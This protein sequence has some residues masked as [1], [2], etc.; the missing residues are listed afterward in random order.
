MNFFDTI[1]EMGYKLTP[2][3]DDEIIEISKEY[4][5]CE[6]HIT[7]YLKEKKIIGF[8]EVKEKLFDINDMAHIYQSFRELQGDIKDFA[9]KSKYEVVE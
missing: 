9:S 3:H 4:G 1:T 6:T 8:M 2:L 5:L 7:F